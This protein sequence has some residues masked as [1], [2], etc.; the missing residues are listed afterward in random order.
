MQSRISNHK[1]V[2]NDLEC[3]DDQ[4]AENVGRNV[5]QCTTR[6]PF[7]PSL[8]NDASTSATSLSISQSEGKHVNFSTMIL[9]ICNNQEYKKINS[10]VF[11]SGDQ[12]TNLV[13]DAVLDNQDFHHTNVTREI[14]HSKKQTIIEAEGFTHNVCHHPSKRSL[15]YGNIFCKMGFM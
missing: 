4:T 5:R 7:Q 9:E 2:S 14:H 15:Q 8:G 13:A 6:Q 1:R 11:F 12:C 3:H 10:C